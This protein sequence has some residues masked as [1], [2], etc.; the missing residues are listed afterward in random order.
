[1]RDRPQDIEILSEHFIRV[2]AENNDLPVRS[3]SEAAWDLV[4]QYDH[5]DSAL[6]NICVGSGLLII[7]PLQGCR[8]G[9]Q[10]PGILLLE[11]RS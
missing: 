8:D 5:S 9:L 6:G 10:R 4:N 2:C 3:L 7:Q 1:M 11:T